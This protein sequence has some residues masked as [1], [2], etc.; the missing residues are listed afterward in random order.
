[1]KF[2]QNNFFTLKFPDLFDG[3]VT[4]PPYKRTIPNALGEAAFDNLDFLKKAD[5]ITKDDAFLI[6]FCNFLNA[7]DLKA[8]AAQTNWKFCTH[9]IWDKRPTRTWIA[10]TRPL[11]HT[12]Y[13]LYFIKGSYKLDFRTG[14]TKPPVKRSSFGGKLKSV[15]NPNTAKN[16]QEMYSEILTYRLDHKNKKHPTEKPK[17][18]SKMFSKIIG[19][20]KAVIDPF[21]GSGNLLAHFPNSVGIDQVKY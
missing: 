13:I 16:S 19:E 10:W 7:T 11:R 21:C 4:D 18:F 2:I 14:V 17:E 8:L 1:M 12:E 9:Q 3:V 20:N 6:T 5:S 15:K